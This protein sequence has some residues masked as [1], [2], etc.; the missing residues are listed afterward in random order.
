MSMSRSARGT[1]QEPGRRVRQKAGLNREM[2]AAGFG[3]THPMLAYKPEQAGTRLHLSDTRQL[4]LSQGFP[5][6]WEVVPKTLVARVCLPAVRADIRATKTARRWSSLTRMQ[7]SK[8]LFGARLERASQRD[9]NLCHG[10]VASP[11]P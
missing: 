6:C 2:L 8:S 1:R 4:K 5:G 9:L 10:N 11:G 7:R 3:M